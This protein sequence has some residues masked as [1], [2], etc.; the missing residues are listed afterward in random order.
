[1]PAVKWDFETG[2]LVWLRIYT[3]Q[4]SRDEPAL[5]IARHAPMQNY[6]GHYGHYTILCEG[7]LWGTTRSSLR[8][9]PPDTESGESGVK[10]V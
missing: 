5:V 2:E 3:G 10:S 9:M 4:A 6:A 1:M 7:R 8:A